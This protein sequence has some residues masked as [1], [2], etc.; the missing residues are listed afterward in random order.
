MKR[1]NI[2]TWKKIPF[3]SR[4]W[5]LNREEK[6]IL[7]KEQVREYDQKVGEYWGKR[8]SQA[9]S[10]GG[11]VGMAMSCPSSLASIGAFAILKILIHLPV[12]TSLIIASALFVT[13]ITASV[14]LAALK[15]RKHGVDGMQNPKDWKEMILKQRTPKEENSLKKDHPIMTRDAFENMTLEIMTSR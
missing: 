5:T 9:A 15:S 4:E 2:L 3:L 1:D 8:A 11:L 10:F 13:L 6:N 7:S 14:S 12:S